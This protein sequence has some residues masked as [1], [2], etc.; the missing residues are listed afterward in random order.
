[1]LHNYGVRKRLKLRLASPLGVLQCYASSSCTLAR[2][3]SWRTWVRQGCKQEREKVYLP[4]SRMLRST[5]DVLR[6][7][8][9]V[10]TFV[11]IRNV[12]AILSFLSRFILPLLSRASP[13]LSTFLCAALRPV[14]LISAVRSILLMLPK[15][16]PARGPVTSCVSLQLWRS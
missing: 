6:V 1:M 3:A 8:S 12:L 13:D 11:L 2:R 9:P 15:G 14:F 7:R 10:G 5:W 4:L 16:L